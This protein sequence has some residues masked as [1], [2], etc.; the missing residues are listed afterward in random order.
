M[1][2]EG[3]AYGI[4]GS[5]RS[6]EKNSS[7]NFTKENTKFCLSLNYNADDDNETVNFP[8]HFV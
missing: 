8:I 1:L 3:P 2:G 4:N 6:P 7:I 5:F